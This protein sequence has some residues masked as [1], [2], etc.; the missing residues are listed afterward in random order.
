MLL[1]GSQVAAYISVVGR[2]FGIIAERYFAQPDVMVGHCHEI[3]WSTQL[4]L[5]AAGEG[6]CLTVAVAVGGARV[7]AIAKAVGV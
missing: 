4:T 5:N 6:N 2:V 7:V 3:E 1:R